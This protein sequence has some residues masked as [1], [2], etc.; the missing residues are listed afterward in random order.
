MTVV[1][2]ESKSVSEVQVNNAEFQ[3]N[4]TKRSEQK[5]LSQQKGSYKINIEVVC[6]YI[7][8]VHVYVSVYT[9][10]QIQLVLPRIVQFQLLSIITEEFGRSLLYFRIV[11]WRPTIT[12]YHRPR[13]FRPPLYQ[14][15]VHVRVYIGLLSGRRYSCQFKKGCHLCKP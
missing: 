3:V 4:C 2:P 13:F 10:Y 5:P 9:V 14:E 1:R 15:H 11:K 7:H 12:K 6:N 8:P